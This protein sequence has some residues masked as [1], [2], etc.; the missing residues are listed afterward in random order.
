MDPITI[1]YAVGTLGM[2]VGIP[3]A[4]SLAGDDVGLD[5]KYLFAIPGLAA[6]MYLIMAFDVGA[7]TFQGYHVPI[8]RYVDWALTTP[9]LVGYTAYIAGVGKRVIFGAALVDVLMILFG[10]AAVSLPP[11]SQWV[12]FGLSSLCHLGLLVTLYGPIRRSAWEQSS[13]R[14]RLGR[15]LLNYIGLLWLTYPVVWLLGP[16]LQVVSSTGVAVVITYMDVTAKVP[17]V[18]FIYRARGNF[19][20]AEESAEESTSNSNAP[21]PTAT[22]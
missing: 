14:R 21:A 19:V 11:P 7:V 15:L 16:G 9:L 12:F 8:P 17:F 13:T 2:L 18:Y 1:V 20:R 6:L 5:F 4:L 10:V 22:A 3:P